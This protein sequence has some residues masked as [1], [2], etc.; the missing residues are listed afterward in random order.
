MPKKSRIGKQFQQRLIAPSEPQV[1][2]EPAQD[3]AWWKYG[4]VLTREQSE[5]LDDL[6]VSVFLRTRKKIER[7]AI[8]RALI[9][10]LRTERIDISD[11]SNQ[12]DILEALRAQ[13][14]AGKRDK[15]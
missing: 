3:I 15:K 13:L 2:E 5:F 4:F 11:C 1:Q 6:V 7:S 10:L 8:I 12:Q 14:K 9:D